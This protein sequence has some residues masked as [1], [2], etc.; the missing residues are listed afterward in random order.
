MAGAESSAN[1]GTR[2]SEIWTVM[3]CLDGKTTDAS[4]GIAAKASDLAEGRFRTAAVWLSSTLKDD[5]DKVRKAQAVGVPLIRQIQAEPQPGYLLAAEHAERLVCL[6]RKHKP[7]VILL[8]AS[9]WGRT[10]AACAATRLETGL[11]ADCTELRLDE[12][13]LLEQVRP[14]LSGNVL[15]TIVCPERRPQMATVR[16]HVFA[17]PRLSP[18]DLDRQCEGKRRVD[19]VVEPASLLVKCGERPTGSKRLCRVVEDKKIDAPDLSRAAVVVAG[20]RGIG[21]KD[22]FGVLAELAIQLGGVVA[23]SRAAVQSGWIGSAWQVGQTGQTIRPRLYIAVGISGTVQHLV[24]VQRARK[25]VAINRD[26]EAPIMACSDLRV[27]GDWRE[28]LPKLIGELK[29]L[30]HRGQRGVQPN[31]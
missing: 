27:V 18:G 19:I 3:E 26:P 13:G 16:P 6:A 9:D 25:I 8:P 2:H 11:T 15:A 4:W 24:G 22:G 31:G 14:A 30:A 7:E 29:A 23:G 5:D 1:T 20:G 17:A 12:Q 21:G 10:V 28:V